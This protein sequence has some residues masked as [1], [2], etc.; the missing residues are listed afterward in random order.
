MT[1]TPRDATCHA[2][3]APARP[4]PMIVTIRPELATEWGEI[5]DTG[6]G[7]RGGAGGPNPESHSGPTPLRRGYG[8]LLGPRVIALLVVAEQPA[9]VALGG[10]LDEKRRTA[11]GARLGHRAVP[12]HEVA[13]RIVRAAEEEL[14]TLRF[15]LDDLAAF[16]GVLRAFDPGAL[17]LDVLAL[18]IIRAGGELTVPPLLDDQIRL[19]A[20]AFLVQ[21]LIGFRRAQA[22]LPGRDQLSRGLALRIAR[23]REELS[24]SAALH[25]HRSAAILTRLDLV[26]ARLRFRLLGLDLARVRAIRIGAARNERPELADPFEHRRST[27]VA[28]L[29]DL[30]ALLEIDH[31]FVGARQIL[32]ELA[33]ERGQRTGIVG[34]A[35][36]DLVEIV[37]ERPRVVD[38]DDVVEALGQ[39]VRN[40]P[41][42]RRRLET[43]FNLVDVLAILEH[44]NDRRVGARPADA[45]LF[46]LLHE[47]GLGESCGRLRELLF[48]SERL[49]LEHISLG[50]GRQ[51]AGGSIRRGVF[52]GVTITIAIA[53]GLAIERRFARLTPGARLART[54]L[55]RLGPCRRAGHET[56]NRHPAGEFRDGALHAEHVLAGGHVD[57]GFVKRRW[58][59][60][61]RDESVPDQ[62]IER[63]LIRREIWPHGLG[64]VLQRRRSN[65][66]VSVLG[67]RFR[68][69]EVR[70]VRHEL[71][72]ERRLDEVTH[73]DQ[74]LI[75]HAHRVGA[76]IGD[77]AARQARN[78]DAALV[79][80][81]REH[82][83]LLDGEASGLLQLARDERR[84]RVALALLRRDGR[85]GPRGALERRQHGV[86]LCLAPDLDGVGV[87]L[88]ELRLELRWLGGCQS[89]EDVPVLVGH[90][91]LD[92]TL[93]VAD[94]LE[95]H[96][97]HAAGAQPAADFVPEERADLV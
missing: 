96:R 9:A 37:L 45:V 76:H 87:L 68:L 26:L 78:I 34:L 14:S 56:I 53:T 81:L 3:S 80:L 77:E 79:Q 85:D 15:A 44:R 32:F 95:G 71:A 5:T 24:E 64:V 39:Q 74:R 58:R 63:E 1:G 18:G 62:A 94:Q 27:F 42:E 43:A 66:L 88:D 13:I 38:V 12:E 97:L 61:R 22:T 86:R 25:G 92:L 54:E 73:G 6:F 29:A 47:R 33:V 31:F 23:T 46:E 49:Q 51:H 89:R 16:L 48:G 21:N 52:F 19:A 4:P 40:H 28:C 30:D 70:L 67:V 36:L 55:H 20:R 8:P 60:L 11:F 17:V 41:A 57:D 82:H 84:R 90:E 35:L 2:A 10:L 7:I 91:R 59:H 75:G 83:R 50:K 93:A 72:A 69:E 65:R